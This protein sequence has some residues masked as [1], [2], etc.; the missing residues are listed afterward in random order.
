[1]DDQWN[2][3]GNCD[4][5]RRQK[6]CSKPCKACKRAEAIRLRN[7]ACDI[8]AMSAAKVLKEKVKGEEK[9]EV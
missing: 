2:S 9:D 7:I 1:M 6:Y 5:R 3:N 4:L 8:L